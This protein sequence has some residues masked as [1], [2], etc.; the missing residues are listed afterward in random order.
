M[1]KGI[2]G[3]LDDQYDELKEDYLSHE[4]WQELE[5]IFSFLEAFFFATKDTEGK[6]NT[7][8]DMLLS[9][10]YL[11]QHYKEQ[12]EKCA[13][14]HHPR[15]QARVLASWFK[16]DKYY[17]VTDDTPIYATAVLLHPAYRKGYFDTHWGHQKQY[18][19]P[20]M[21]PARK[22]WQKHFK[23]RSEELTPTSQ[24]SK[25]DRWRIPFGASRLRQQALFMINSETNLR[26]SSGQSLT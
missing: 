19:E 18:I 10:D 13:L 9:M 21:K 23:P 14:S 5:D 7:L 2:R 22:L 3:C 17:K 25:S 24:N 8:D 6:V 4:A 16:F 11:V 12:K 1:R 15:L 26:T 20:T